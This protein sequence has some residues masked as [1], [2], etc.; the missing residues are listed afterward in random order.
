M[1]VLARLDQVRTTHTTKLRIVAKQIRELSTLL[2]E[3]NIGETSD[4]LLKARYAD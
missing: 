3:V 1:H 2:H 4:L